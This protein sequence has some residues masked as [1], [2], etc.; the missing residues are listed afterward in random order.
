MEILTPLR[1]WL[2]INGAF[3]SGS[4]VLVRVLPA[5]MHPEDLERELARPG[6]V[7]ATCH[8]TTTI[9]PANAVRSSPCPTACG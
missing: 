7:E 6:V 1:D 2:E 3:T 8:L 9:Q 4:G 5:D